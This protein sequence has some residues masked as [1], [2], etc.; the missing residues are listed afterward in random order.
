MQNSI[1]IQWKDGRVNL[2]IDNDREN[3]NPYPYQKDA[4]EEMNKHF[5]Q[6]KNKAGILWIPTGGGKTV[7]AVKWLYDNALAQNKRILWIAHRLSLLKQAAE[8]FDRL[9]DKNII[10]KDKGL[11]AALVAGEYLSWKSVDQTD[12]IVFSTTQSAYQN[13]SF[14]E[15]MITQSPNGLYVVVD[16][17]HHAQAPANQKILRLLKDKGAII[18]GLTATPYHIDDRKTNALWN[19]FDSPERKPVT[20]VKKQFLIGKEFLANPNPITIQTHIKQKDIVEVGQQITK[21]QTRDSELKSYV[22]KRLGENPIRNKLIAEHYAKN[23]ERYG[24]TIIFTPETLA[25]K[26]L[27][28]ELAKY[29]IA[30]DYIQHN[31]PSK[32]NEDIMDRFR[33]DKSLMVLV[34]TEMC[35]EGFD[36]PQTKTVFLTRPTQSQT[37]VQ[38]MVGRAMRG[39]EA[40]GNEECYLV[41]FVDTWKDFNPIDPEIVI[42]SD[43]YEVTNVSKSSAGTPIQIPDEV[44]E[45][46]Y[47]LLLTMH[48]GEIRNTFESIPWGWYIWDTPENSEDENLSDKRRVLIFAPQ[49]EGYNLLEESIRKGVLQI[50]NDISDGFVE[51][52][53]NKFFDSCQDPTPRSEDLK[54]LLQAWK[55]GGIDNGSVLKITFEERE[56]YNTRKIAQQ[57]I[58]EDLTESRQEELIKSLW[59]DETCQKCFSSLDRL[60]ED[61]N[62]YKIQIKSKNQKI[63]EIIKRVAPEK[64]KIVIKK[65]SEGNAGYALREILESVGSNL[66]LFPK[67]KPQVSAIEYREKLTRGAWGVCQYSNVNTILISEELNTPSIPL[68]VVEFLIYHELLHA[69]GLYRH[70]ANFREREAKFIP[71]KKAIENAKDFP[72]WEISLNAKKIEWQALC[73]QFL[74]TWSYN[75]TKDIGEY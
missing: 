1:K 13:T 9:F 70:D 32:E 38:Q 39:I 20:R 44:I 4:W 57:I 42:N 2:P 69:D 17:C 7:I 27:V 34:N 16:E 14:V 56:K 25:N 33:K 60:I 5:I 71:S 26:R 45:E 46:C 59:E 75:F 51:A 74:D 15:Q 55:D 31:R 18:I 48:I 19:F 53:R 61:V 28:D 23:K 22:L 35:T 36:A 54:A 43:E 3:L 29:N 62:R 58:D 67:G 30:A 66:K 40:G 64:E 24:K 41:T 65:W 49:T 8:T 6:Q 21:N 12:S 10:S 11:L 63:K 50:E 52:I 73:D 37:L 72:Q 68:A 47:N